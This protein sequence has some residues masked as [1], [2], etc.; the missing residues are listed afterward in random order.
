[1]KQPCDHCVQPVCDYRRCPPYQKWF[2]AAWNEFRRNV[3]GG[4]WVENTQKEG[5]FTYVHPN[6]IRKYLENGPCSR[7]D[8]ADVC[9]APCVAYR[10]WWDA[11]MAWRRWKLQHAAL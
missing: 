7:C 9:D 6:L 1:M 8:W 11:R 5:K 3:P 4:C 10:H 2:K